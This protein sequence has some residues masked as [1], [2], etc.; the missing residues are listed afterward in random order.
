MDYPSVMLSQVKS[1]IREGAL[2]C[3]RPLFFQHAAIWIRPV[4]GMLFWSPKSLKVLKF[5]IFFII[6]KVFTA[7]GIAVKN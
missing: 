6:T 7:T 1:I 3:Q 2:V 5:L 4:Y